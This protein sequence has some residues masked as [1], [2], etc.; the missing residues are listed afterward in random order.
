MTDEARL[1]EELEAHG[2]GRF[3][4]T[5]AARR[6]EGECGGGGLEAARGGL[7]RARL[8]GHKIERPG[9]YALACA[10]RDAE[11]TAPARRAAAGSATPSP[12]PAPTQGVWNANVC[13]AGVARAL[14]IVAGDAAALAEAR[15]LARRTG[16]CV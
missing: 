16:R 10:R 12:P 11:S 15:E 14:R 4:A 6:V 1:I 5:A 3:E 2:V 7:A 13:S 9:A 8:R